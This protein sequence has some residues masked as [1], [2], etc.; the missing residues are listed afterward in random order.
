M[1][2]KLFILQLT[3]CWV[4]TATGLLFRRVVGDVVEDTESPRRG[5]D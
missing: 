4:R 3:C 2:E 5:R 1:T